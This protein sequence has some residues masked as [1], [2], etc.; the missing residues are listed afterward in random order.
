MALA[1]F[2]TFTTYG[3][4]LHGSEKGLGSV[5]WEHSEYGAEFVEPDAVREMEARGAMSQSVY[6]MDARR[7]E[8][9]RDA[10]VALA[11]EKGWRL[12]AMHVRSNHV[13]VV[14]WAERDPGRLMSDLKAR[15]S[16]ELTAAGFE[17]AQRRRWTRHGSTRH[18]FTNEEVEKKIK[19]TLDEQGTPM[20]VYDGRNERRAK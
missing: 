12:L 10:V 16:R 4:W 13:H 5:Y 14:I 15:A 8:V 7:R 2:I 6:T 9:V 1:Y 11:Q 20:A 19:Y 17:N 3:T 18:L